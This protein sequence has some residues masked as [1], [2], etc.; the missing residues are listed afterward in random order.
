MVADSINESLIIKNFDFQ[1]LHPTLASYYAYKLCIEDQPKTR[2]GDHA[3]SFQVYQSPELRTDF[4]KRSY[5]IF[6][7]S[8]QKLFTTKQN[9]ILQQVCQEYQDLILEFVKSSDAELQQNYLSLYGILHLANVIMFDP[10]QGS[11]VLFQISEWIRLNF[12]EDLMSKFEQVSNYSQPRLHSN[13]WPVVKICTMRGHFDAVLRLFSIKEGDKAMEIEMFE[14]LASSYPRLEKYTTS[15]G[16]KDAWCKWNQEAVFALESLESIEFEDESLKPHFLDLY[17]ILAGNEDVIYN[18]AESWHDALL[19]LL[20]FQNP[21]Y[22]MRGVVALV[23][24]LS[25]KIPVDNVVDMIHV[26][27]LKMDYAVVV[28][29]SFQYDLW[30]AAHLVELLDKS[31]LLNEL[32]EDIGPSMDY[33]LT[34]FYALQFAEQLLNNGELR[35]TALQYYSQCTISGKSFL[36]ELVPRLYTSN[37]SEFSKLLEFCRVHGLK[38]ALLTLH[39]IAGQEFMMKGEYLDAIVNF[40]EVEDSIHIAI[41]VDKLLQK[42]IQEG[43]LDYET[44]VSQVPT[45]ALYKSPALAFLVRY[46]QFQQHYKRCEFREAADLVVNLF[47]SGTVPDTYRQTLLLDTLPLLEGEI[48]VFSSE[49]VMELM[50]FAE[51]TTLTDYTNNFSP[52]KSCLNQIEENEDALVLLKLALNRSLAAAFVIES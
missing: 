38:N 34:E 30:L 32:K 18:I 8:R 50:R 26:S 25:E 13:F 2:H 51:H 43:S 29:L 11:P 4:V 24:D 9:N 44:V 47:V 33:Q 5:E 14:K 3:V 35:F 49:Q 20:L 16:F 37:K 10:V 27:I 23:S 15:I 28:N 19:S 41:I 40:L 39:K 17:S 31:G 7:S 42:F 48:N 1:P 6:A 12:T 45:A 52:E 21:L 22:T 46:T 36:D